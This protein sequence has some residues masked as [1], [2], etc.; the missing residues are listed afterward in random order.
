MRNV[1]LMDGGVGTS[2]WEKSSDRLPVWQY[3]MVNPG[4]VR[5]LA[6]EYADAGAQI[7]L[8][9]TFAVNR[10]SL[11]SSAWEVPQVIAR[12]VELAREG[13]G[14]RAR[15]ALS[16]GPL[17]VL[18]EPYG[19]LEEDEAHA[20]FLEIMQAGAGA[21][22]LLVQTF[23]DLAM[24]QVAL[25][26]AATLDK[27]VMAAF[28]FEARGRTMMGNSVQD[29]VEGLAAY[30]LEAIGLN[31][32]LGP[33]QALPILKEF[34]QHT[35]RPLLFKPNAGLPVGGKENPEMDAQAFADETAKAAQA[36]ATYIGGC[37]G[38]NPAYI[39]ALK[40]KLEEMGALH[41]AEI[42]GAVGCMAGTSSAGTI[43]R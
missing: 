40:R 19:D 12:A 38:S 41:C 7:V 43:G 29:I 23:M 13:A 32:S 10:V 31:C 9:N 16:V 15:V 42:V 4:I 3:N 26:A 1:I 18:M 34:A 22:V 2:L 5:E 37:C 14:G 17:P 6:G 27:P 21:D 25:R 39:R 11:K 36:G 30:P 35:D 24:M 8:A 28:S 20:M 33:E